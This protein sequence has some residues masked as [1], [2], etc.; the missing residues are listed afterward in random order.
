MW[1]GCEVAAQGFLA[2]SS[3][4]PVVTYTVCPGIDLTVGTIDKKFKTNFHRITFTYSVSKVIRRRRS[5]MQ[6]NCSLY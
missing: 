3:V 4:V 6:V 2:K 5:V 1:L